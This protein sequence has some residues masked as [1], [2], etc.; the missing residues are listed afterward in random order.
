[1]ALGAG[2]ACGG[3]PL[4][5]A[6]VP[7]PVA[8]LLDGDSRAAVDGVDGPVPRCGGSRRSSAYLTELSSTGPLVVVLDHLHRADPSSLRLL[9]H[10]AES[11][12]ASRLLLVVSY[13]SDEA[14]NLA[15][16]AGR[17]GPRG[18]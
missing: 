9:A 16:T 11:V 12:P 10:L 13:R 8:G 14:A 2:A 18:R 17:P 5:A 3:Q 15:E 6:S 4:P 7:G 1:M